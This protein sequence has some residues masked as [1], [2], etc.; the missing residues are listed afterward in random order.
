[1]IATRPTP[2][3]MD[4]FIEGPQK[5]VRATATSVTLLEKSERNQ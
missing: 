3:K 1:M 2:N 4:P 5:N